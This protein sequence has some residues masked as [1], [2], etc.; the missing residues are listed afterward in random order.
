MEVAGSLRKQLA[1]G[2]PDL[3]R[4]M[5]QG[6]KRLLPGVQIAYF[7]SRRRAMTSCW[8]S[9]DPSPRIRSGASR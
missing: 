1:Q 4:E 5:V 7:S 2:S 6:D 8:I 9:F 3:L